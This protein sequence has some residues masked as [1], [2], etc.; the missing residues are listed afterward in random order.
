M[1]YRGYKASLRLRMA[2][3]SDWNCL[4][5]GTHTMRD[6]S[7]ICVLVQSCRVGAAEGVS[8]VAVRSTGPVEECPGGPRFSMRYS[9]CARCDSNNKFKCKWAVARWRWL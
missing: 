5:A 6:T 8:S 9:C 4:M 7:D 2:A 3:R 1:C